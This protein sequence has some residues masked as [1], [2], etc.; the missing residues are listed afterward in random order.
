MWFSERITT[1]TSVPVGALL[2]IM[3]CVDPERLATSIDQA[4]KTYLV[5]RE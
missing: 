1:I 2:R 3:A 4:L 5:G